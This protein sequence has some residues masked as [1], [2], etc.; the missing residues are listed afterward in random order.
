MNVV[1]PQPE[2]NEVFTKT[3]GLVLKRPTPFP[4]P[5]IVLKLGLQGMGESL[6]LASQ[7]CVPEVLETHSYV[8]QFPELETA[9]NDLIH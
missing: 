2:T 7:R 1:S 3:L 9:L 6:L 8:F 4:V 5:A